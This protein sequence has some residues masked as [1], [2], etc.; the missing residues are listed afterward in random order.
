[1]DTRATTADW[2]KEWKL[3]YCGG[4]FDGEGCISLGKGHGDKYGHLIVR[5]VS[6]DMGSLEL[7]SEAIG[8]CVQPAKRIWRGR[9]IRYGMWTLYGRKAQSALKILLPY[10]ITKKERA[11]KAC[12]LDIG[13]GR[14]SEVEYLKR[15]Q[16]AQEGPNFHQNSGKKVNDADRH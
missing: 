3:A 2:P 16:F 12:S 6:R 11:L 1:M 13:R 10:L 14:V 4:Y 7:M 5:I 8:G 9:L 15:V